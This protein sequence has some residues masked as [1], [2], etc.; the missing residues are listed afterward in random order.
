METVKRRHFFIHKRLQTKYGI[1]TGCLLIVYTIIILAAIFAPH[2]MILFSDASLQ[3]R[4]EA[5][6]ALLLLHNNIWPAILLIIINFGFLSIY[7][8][9]R[10]AGPIFVFER[11]T[12]AISLGDIKIRAHLRKNDDLQELARDLNMMADDMEGLVVS[13]Q[14]EHKSLSSYSSEIRAELESQQISAQRISDILTRIDADRNS[15]EKI[16]EKYGITQK[17]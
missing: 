15:L 3:Q 8:T 1:L 10:I 7:M 16:L 2:V 13:I 11:M 9:H 14:E 12:R 6:E 4:S 17:Y 5:A